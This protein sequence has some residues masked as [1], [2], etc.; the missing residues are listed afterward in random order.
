VAQIESK[1][2]STKIDEAA[3]DATTQDK[4][5]DKVAA[6]KESST[7][8]KVSIPSKTV[9]LPKGGSSN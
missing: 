1:L 7:E 3:K 8:E 5:A 4:A 2:A 6:D 9:S